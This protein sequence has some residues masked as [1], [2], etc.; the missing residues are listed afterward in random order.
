MA[1]EN[2]QYG[3]KSE[4]YM[5]YVSRAF[6][7]RITKIYFTVSAIYVIIGYICTRVTHSLV[8][9]FVL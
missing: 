3:C 9:I 1:S 5:V 4:F 6:L 2:G 8:C 7:D